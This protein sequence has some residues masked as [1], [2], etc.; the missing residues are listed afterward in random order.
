[1][2]HET[3]DIAVLVFWLAWTILSLTNPAL[4]HPRF[5]ALFSIESAMD[6]VY[7]SITLT[8]APGLMDV[9]KSATAPTIEYF[10]TLP[11]DPNKLWAVYLLVLEKDGQ[12]PRTYVGSSTNNGSGVRSRMQT[13]DRRSCG[14]Y[15]YVMP[16]FVERS[17]KEGFVITHKCLLVW[18]PM[19]VASKQYALRA[20]FLTLETVF[21]LCFWTM[22]SRVKDYFMPALCPW[23]RDSFTY[24]GCC[25]HFSIN[26]GMSTANLA[27]PTDPRTPEEIDNADVERKKLYNRLTI[28]RKGEGVHA[29]QAKAFRDQAYAKQT[30]KCDVCVLTFP[31]N[32]KL[33][34]HEQTGPHNRKIANVVHV[35]KG[36]G[37]SQLAVLR[38][39]HYCA[40]CDHAASTKA[41]LAIHKKGI[42]HAKK[43]R[44]L[45]LTES[46]PP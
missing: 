9:F 39:K 45:G 12:R 3:D 37:G 18:T 36:H 24:D 32:A 16:M 10:K 20:L 40:I 30:Y 22:K 14:G 1:M 44:V 19:P 29:A 26:E 33:L 7:L 28:A 31:N 23:P 27:I 35:P 46:T 6:A 38:K 43:L 11:L 15:D 2:L 8:F 5:S 34:E 41:R 25:N 13:Y 17:L 4:K 21:A 42:R